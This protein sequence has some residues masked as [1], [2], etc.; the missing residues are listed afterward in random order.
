MA[1]P[2]ELVLVLARDL[3]PGGLDFT[4]VIDRPFAPV[5]AAVAQ[6]G[7][8]LPRGK[9]E[10]DPSLK[11]IIPYLL[12]RDSE[13][14]FLMKRTKAGGDERLHDRYTI[15]VG[16]HVNPGD[17][18]VLGGLKREWREE[19]AADFE[20]EFVSLGLLND[21]SNPVGAVHLGL[22][23]AADADGR[24]VAIRETH[25]LSGEFVAS[26][27]VAE[28]QDRLETWSAL[29]FDFLVGR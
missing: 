20:P 19:I 16:G 3:V 27:V 1:T 6:S 12:L 24:P 23:Y 9:V 13:R 14:I 7:Q 11:Q 22:V 21:D 8:F 28:V 10:D 17:A 26:D 29:L 25:K 5:L 15:G 18:D 4:G 2:D